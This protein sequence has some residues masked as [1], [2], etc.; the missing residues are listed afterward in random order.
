MRR[1][2]RFAVVVPAL[3]ALAVVGTSCSD[4]ENGGNGP[5]IT[6]TVL[7]PSGQPVAGAGILLEYTFGNRVARALGD[8]P[9][10]GIRFDVPE[11]GYARVWITGPC[12]RGTVRVLADGELPAGSHLLWWTGENEAGQI[13]PPGMYTMHAQT[14]RHRVEQELY[15]DG[16]SWPPSPPLESREWLAFTDADGRFTL[17]LGCLPF[18]Q[19]M[20]ATDE[21]GQPLQTLT[22]RNQARFWAVTADL[23][24]ISTGF[25]PVDPQQGAQVELRYLGKGDD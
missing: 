14:R 7:D 13:M 6:G 15:F 1:Q 18:G 2:S 21:T 10:T 9:A 16:G 3:I 23:G 17:P 12:D 20:V 19:S 24:A 25:V 5:A 8:K 4:D 22:I 11:P